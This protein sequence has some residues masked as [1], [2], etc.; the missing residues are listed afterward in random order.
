MIIRHD[1]MRSCD[2]IWA[3]CHEVYIRRVCAGVPS[4]INRVV[5][6]QALVNLTSKFEGQV[7]MNLGP[8]RA[9]GL[10]NHSSARICA[11]VYRL[12]D[13]IDTHRVANERL[14]HR[15]S[16]SDKHSHIASC[17]CTFIPLL[18]VLFQR[19]Q[20]NKRQCF[21]ALQKLQSTP[22]GSPECALLCERLLRILDI[23]TSASKHMGG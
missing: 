22:F 3:K 7:Y 4:A 14:G 20:R 12:D 19:L 16:E 11:A 17:T 2:H 23:G 15:C 13:V 18:L 8:M 21:S 9:L 5:M 1:I 6:C 10:P